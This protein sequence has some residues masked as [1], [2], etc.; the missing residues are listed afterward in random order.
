[1]CTEPRHRDIRFFLLLC[2]LRFRSNR[3]LTE[4]RSHN[5][6]RSGTALQI[7]R[8]CIY[9]YSNVCPP[10]LVL[11]IQSMSSLRIRLLGMYRLMG[12]LSR[13]ALLQI[14]WSISDRAK[15]SELISI[16][17][18][19][20]NLSRLGSTNRFAIYAISVRSRYSFVALA[21]T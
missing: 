8:F 19:E 13:M 3:H 9:H 6:L 14:H 21:L 5:L 1:M 7:H 4:H 11:F 2:I 12:S 10:S 20:K 16:S 18:S 17:L 15:W